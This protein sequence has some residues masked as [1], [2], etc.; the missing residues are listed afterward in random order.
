MGKILIVDDEPDLVKVLEFRLKANNYE[1]LGVGN[2]QSAVDAVKNG[3]IDLV[4]MDY[5]LPD[6]SGLEATNQIRSLQGHE[7]IPVIFISA[8]QEKLDEIPE[9][10]NSERYLKP[11]PPETLL[12][13]VQRHVKK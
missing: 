5:Y 6:I 3:D 7:N 1:T 4:F 12:A 13:A 8:S 2:G 9:I 10:G 11:V